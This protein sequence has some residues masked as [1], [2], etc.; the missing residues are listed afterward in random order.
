MTKKKTLARTRA[1][2][3]PGVPPLSELQPKQAAGSSTSAWVE[4]RLVEIDD[5]S[6]EKKVFE[7]VELAFVS[8]DFALSAY[9]GV[10]LLLARH[11]AAGRHRAIG[12]RLAGWPL[13]AARRAARLPM[14]A[15][16]YRRRAKRRLA[17][18]KVLHPSDRREY[19][20]SY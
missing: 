16:S 3:V 19:D 14:E 12:P 17:R 11:K 13:V 8:V 7:R 6:L 2:K 4:I 1:P 20:T 5:E 18:Q 15:A 10:R 9:Q